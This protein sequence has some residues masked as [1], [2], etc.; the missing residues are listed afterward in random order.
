MRIT[1]QTKDE[2]VAMLLS[3]G[4]PAVLKLTRSVGVTAGSIKDTRAIAEL[5]WSI[6]QKNQAAR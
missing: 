1:E 6:A 3:W 4:R 5:L 2:Y